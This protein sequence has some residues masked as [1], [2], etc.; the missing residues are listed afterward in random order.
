MIVRDARGPIWPHATMR[1]EENPGLIGNPIEGRAAARQ[2]IG[3]N[4]MLSI[5]RPAPMTA[6]A[7]TSV[8]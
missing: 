1:A 6:P 3:I 5:A 7:R 8:G 2:A 4:T